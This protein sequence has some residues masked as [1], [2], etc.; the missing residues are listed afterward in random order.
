M[1]RGTNGKKRREDETE[2]QYE[3]RIVS[4]KRTRDG[5]IAR[6]MSD[7][8]KEAENMELMERGRTKESKREKESGEGRTS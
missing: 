7:R 8:S 6:A 2:D 1:R 5:K 4:Q 3:K